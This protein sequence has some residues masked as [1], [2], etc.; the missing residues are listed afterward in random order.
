MEER[1]AELNAKVHITQNRADEIGHTSNCC[2]T[3]LRI[4]D[5]ARYA[6]KNE[7]AYGLFRG[8]EGCSMI[9]CAKK[10]RWM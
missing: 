6:A 3:D 8:F 7:C 2:W 10:L 1:T 9:A 4:V 5:D